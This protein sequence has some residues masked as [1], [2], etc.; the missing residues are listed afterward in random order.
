MKGIII[1][2]KWVASVTLL[3][4]LIIFTNT[5]QLKQ[6]INLKHI[7][8]NNSTD[9][10]VNK[11]IVLNYL[12]AKSVIIDSVLRTGF[13]QYQL[14][15][16]LEQHNEIKEVEVFMN[17]KGDINILIEQKQAIVRVKS[18][19]EDYYLDEFGQKM[20][21]S[22]HYTPKLIVATGKI[23][24]QDN[25]GIYEFIK[26]INKSDFW[27]SQITQIHFENDDIILI[28]RVGNQRINI[29]DFSNIVEKL[30]NLYQF[31]KIVIPEQGWRT[32]S[33]INLKFK[34]QIVC[35]KD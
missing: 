5:R 10:F 8:I 32:Y 15:D 24:T 4:V 6:K 35:V 18:D 20:M 19:T 26:K 12:K 33:D 9:N 7:K 29:G 17:Q 22:D 3:A 13:N 31:Y 16:I 2:F 11:K 21:V 34:N 27:R 25:I 1:I 28:P 23:D 14:E 30:E